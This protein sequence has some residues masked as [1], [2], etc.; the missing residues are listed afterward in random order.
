M[1]KLGA[2]G[3]H[4]HSG[5]RLFHFG[6]KYRARRRAGALLGAADTSRSVAEL[7]LSPTAFGDPA[8]A[9]GIRISRRPPALSLPAEPVQIAS[10]FRCRAG[11]AASTRSESAP[12]P[13][14]GNS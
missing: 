12:A 6:E 3:N 4:R 11:D 13:A 8:H 9:R 10:G 5:D 2:S 14:L 1:R 7:L